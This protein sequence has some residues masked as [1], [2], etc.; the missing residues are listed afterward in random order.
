[1]RE[2]G[3]YR[4]KHKHGDWDNG[5]SHWDIMHWGNPLS[6]QEG[7]WWGIANELP[8]EDEDFEE[9]GERIIP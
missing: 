2:S 7:G 9:I 6:G 5:V 1:M 8:L 4:V 3:F